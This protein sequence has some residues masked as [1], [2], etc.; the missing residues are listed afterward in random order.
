MLDRFEAFAADRLVAIAP[1]QQQLRV[2]V[3]RGERRLQLVRCVGD[4]LAFARE[5]FLEPREQIVEAARQL[6][7]LVVALRAGASAGRAVRSRSRASRERAGRSA[8]IACDASDRIRER[9][10]KDR[11]NRRG[12]TTIVRLVCAKVRLSS[13]SD[14]AT[15]TTTENDA[16]AQAA[17][18][19]SGYGR[20]SIV[21]AA[22][23]ARVFCA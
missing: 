23:R 6:A 2:G 3:D 19:R 15:W 7:D 10:D 12:S 5:R 16:A 8:P 13:S 18:P 20:P 17:D 4:E 11:S 22:K 14:S 21:D 1:A 9:D